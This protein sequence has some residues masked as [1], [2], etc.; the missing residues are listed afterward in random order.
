M[1]VQEAHA[2]RVCT[3]M[4]RTVLELACLELWEGLGWQGGIC[5]RFMIVVVYDERAREKAG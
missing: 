4:A 2:V 1:G 5:R 3:M